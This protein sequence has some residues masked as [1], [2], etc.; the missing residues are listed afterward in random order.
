MNTAEWEE[1]EQKNAEME[2]L[3]LQQQE[4][5]ERGVRLESALEEAYGEVK[6]LHFTALGKPWTWPVDKVIESK[7]DANPLLAVQFREW[8]QAAKEVCPGMGNIVV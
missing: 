4:V 8:R 6:V 1:P 3:H 2:T 5:R 7:P